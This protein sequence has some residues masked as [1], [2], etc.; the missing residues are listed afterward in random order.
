MEWNYLFIYRPRSSSRW[1]AWRGHHTGGE[2]KEVLFHFLLHQQHHFYSE[3]PFLTQGSQSDLQH[4]GWPRAR[5]HLAEERQRDH[6]GWA[7]HPQVRVGQVC[8]LLRH[9]RGHVR[10]WQVQHPGE[11]QVRHGE[12]G[13]HRKCLHPRC[14]GRQE[15]IDV[16]Q[17]LT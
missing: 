1:S 3:S 6:N 12:R 16:V 8:Q 13:L 9:W 2:G 17:M 4:F 14:G 15:K 5:G 11:E 7:H 10:Q